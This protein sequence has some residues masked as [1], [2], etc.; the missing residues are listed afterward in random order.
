MSI[1]DVFTPPSTHTHTYTHSHTH[2]RSHAHVHS[3]IRH[4]GVPES[5]NRLVEVSSCSAALC[6]QPCGQP[7]PCIYIYTYTHQQVIVKSHFLVRAGSH[8]VM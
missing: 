2:T 5:G 4:N 1:A 7:L 8:A 6:S 3:I